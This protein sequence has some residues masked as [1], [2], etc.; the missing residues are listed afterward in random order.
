[1]QQTRTEIDGRIWLRVTSDDGRF[2]I[3]VC[4][5]DKHADDCVQVLENM[6]ERSKPKPEFEASGWKRR[7][8]IGL[9]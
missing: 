2:L 5:S 8:P 6:L 3:N 7:L 9:T 4:Q 1:M